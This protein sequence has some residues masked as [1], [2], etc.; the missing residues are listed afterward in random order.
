MHKIM[1]AWVFISLIL[2]IMYFEEEKFFQTNFD[3]TG[4][5]DPPPATEDPTSLLADFENFEAQPD[6][7]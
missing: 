6:E 7:L 5:D 3:L 1:L 2:I 4:R